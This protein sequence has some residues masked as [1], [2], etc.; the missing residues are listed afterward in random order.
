MKWETKSYEAATEE[1]TSLNDSA[2]QISPGNS[3]GQI[4][5]TTAEH[6]GVT[7]WNRTGSSL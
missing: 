7:Y 3:C 6:E 4:P 2:E 5:K 1:F